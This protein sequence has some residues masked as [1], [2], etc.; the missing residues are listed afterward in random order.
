MAANQQDSKDL[1]DCGPSDHKPH[2]LIKNERGEDSEK[3]FF[4]S[5]ADLED[6]WKITSA[7]AVA[8]TTSCDIGIEL[9]WN[10]CSCSPVPWGR[11]W[12]TPEAAVLAQV[13]CTASRRN[14]Q[15][16]R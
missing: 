15:N 9:A 12:G 16:Y 11:S 13:T 7:E 10:D 5:E 3:R 1:F 14:T 8:T 6:Q 2:G 4:V